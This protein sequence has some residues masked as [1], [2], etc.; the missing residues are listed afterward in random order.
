MD[1]F[2]ED[3]LQITGVDHDHS[4]IR[5]EPRRPVSDRRGPGALYQDLRVRPLHRWDRFEVL[6]E[7]LLPQV[8]LEI[9]R[10]VVCGPYQLCVSGVMLCI[11]PYM[12]LNYNL[13]IN[14]TRT[15]CRRWK[16][17]SLI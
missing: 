1:T 11:V 16:G 4:G 7:A 8:S 14:S 10:S 9:V 5:A 12:Y 6:C 3:L 15:N 13:Q 2:P 17:K